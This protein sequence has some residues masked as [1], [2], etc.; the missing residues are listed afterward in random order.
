MSPLIA[1]NLDARTFEDMVAEAK[2]RIPRYTPEWTDFNESDPGIVLVQLH[3]WLTETIL[4]QLNR[5]PDAQYVKFLQLLGIDREPAT[6][7][8]ADVSFA[9]KKTV[10]D[11]VL[12][13]GGTRIGVADPD[14]EQPPVFETDRT[15]VALPGKLA[16]VVSV[17]SRRAAGGAPVRRTVANGT[18][19]SSY[20]A[21]RETAPQIDDALYLGIAL[22]S[23]AFPRDEIGLLVYLPD[24]SLDPLVGTHEAPPPPATTCTGLQA[25]GPAGRQLVWEAFQG[26]IAAGRRQQWQ[27]VDVTQDDTLG[28][29]RG[30]YVFLRAPAGFPRENP[31]EVASLVEPDARGNV[32]ELF[33]LRVRIA[34]IEDDAAPSRLDGIVLNAVSA[35]AAQTVADEVVGSSSGRPAQTFTLR[36]TPVLADPP[37]VLEIDEGQGPVAWERV[38]DF[39][40]SA[41]TDA[42][43]VLRRQDGQISFGDGVHGRIPVAGVDNVIARSYHYGG[44]AVGNVGAGTIRNLQSAVPQVDSVGN[45]RSAAGGADEEAEDAAKLR[46]PDVVRTRE[47]AVTADDFRL[48]ALETP[49]ANIAR[50]VALPLVDPAQPGVDVPGAVTVLVVPAAAT[51]KPFPDAATLDL[52]CAY[53]D[54]RRLITTELYIRGPHYAEVELEIEV[55]ARND[56]ELRDV[57]A[58]V[59]DAVTTFLHP[60]RGG[61]DG[62]GWPF[63]GAIHHSDLLQAA[64]SSAAVRRIGTVS[65]WLDGE[66]QPACADVAI[67]AG[68]LVF[69]SRLDVALGYEH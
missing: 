4:Y 25:A 49:G 68:A 47:R 38:D 61:E 40:H 63:G 64:L 17:P 19:G 34:A 26:P 43:Y 18:P 23:A 2:A 30:G 54:D 48:L 9:L 8:R 20:A 21:F 50:A 31:Y 45:R 35:T 22:A 6:P 37:L 65:A 29:T 69:L 13:P 12:I 42:H 59:R 44:G 57:D 15:L 46:A 33:W 7:A 24:P 27:S 36:R 55:I 58:A 51:D 16:E 28:L 60:L 39:G 41:R 1:P 32:P 66:P 10:T 56:A 62:A 67:D 52:V 14:L 3:A 11:P 5:V 53:L